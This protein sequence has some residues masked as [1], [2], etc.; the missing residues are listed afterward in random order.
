[1]RTLTE[2]LM[3][4]EARHNSDLGYKT[5]SSYMFGAEAWDIKINAPMFSFPEPP[6]N[7]SAY[8]S[9]RAFTPFEFNVPSVTEMFK[10]EPLASSTFGSSLGG[11]RCDNPGVIFREVCNGLQERYDFSGHNN[12]SPHLNQDLKDTSKDFKKALGDAHHIDLGFNKDKKFW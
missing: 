9:A 12:T 3:E 6:K 1:M 4:E 8:G 7:S 11:F 10:K 2:T 5:A